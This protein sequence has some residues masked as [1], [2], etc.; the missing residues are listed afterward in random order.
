MYLLP[1]SSLPIRSQLPIR[2]PAATSHARIQ[3]LE[4]RKLLPVHQASSDLRDIL[5]AHNVIIIVGETGSG[6]TTQVWEVLLLH[7]RDC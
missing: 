4:E 7:L 3:L 1:A 5:A 6:K 2:R